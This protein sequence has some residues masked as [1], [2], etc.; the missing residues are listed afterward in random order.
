MHVQEVCKIMKMLLYSK[1]V[2]MNKRNIVIHN[3]SLK[4]EIQIQHKYRLKEK[5]KEL[6]VL[7]LKYKEQ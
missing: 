2:K 5:K 4:G 1:I 7:I 3:L 6:L